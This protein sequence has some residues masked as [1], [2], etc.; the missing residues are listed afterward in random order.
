M[1]RLI[2]WLTAALLA[3]PLAFAALSLGF[4]A[5]LIVPA[6]L[7]CALYAATWLAARPSSFELSDGRLAICFP[8]WTRSLPRGS[9]AS[10]R[11]ADAASLRR[12]LGIAL[13]VGVGG[14][15]G[16]FGWLW[17]SRRGW[18]EMYVSRADGLVW[19]ERPD[20][21]PLLVTP[22]RPEAFLAAIARGGA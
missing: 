20:A 17:S 14:L 2:F 10:A 12:E 19:I 1:S 16:G 5:P 22:E 11:A 13:R 7:L 4:G 21:L 3:I 6:A 9:L 8:L 15:W 18:I